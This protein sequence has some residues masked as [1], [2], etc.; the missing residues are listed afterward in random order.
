MGKRRGHGEGS[1]HLRSDGRWSAVANIGWVGGKRKRKYLY[2]QTRKQVADALKE[3][4]A[5]QTLGMNI[6][7]ARQTVSAF[8]KNWLEQTVKRNNRPRTY[9]KYESDFRHHIE[10]T[11]GKY[12]LAKLTPDHIQDL[13]NDLDDAGL[14][15]RTIRNVRAVI[16][17]ALNKAMKRRHIMINV[18]TLVDV[19]GEIVFKATYLNEEQAVQLL[20]AVK[21]HRF[22]VLYRIALELGLRKGEILGLR[23]E[24]VDFDNAV[25][26]ITGTL[27]R[28]NG[29][30]ERSPTKTEASVRTIALAENL[31]K[32]LKRHKE[33]QDEMRAACGERWVD[34]GLVF[35]TGI[36]TG[37]ETTTLSLHFKS[38][39]AEAKLP[40]ST[41][42][43]D[44]RHSCATL[45]VKRNVHPRVIMAIL[46][47]TQISTTM[48]TYA[49]VLKEVQRDAINV[50]D[51]LL[52]TEEA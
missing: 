24:D 29:R 1:I 5:N 28:Q 8:I 30:L 9:V 32:A 46:G 17:A 18:A 35:T 34:T 41:R 22:E 39:L 19:P 3:L 40:T 31:L 15:Y 38:L 10:P 21:G 25:I 42:F 45:M 4:H 13:L 11:I 20:K 12:Q 36:G 6:A 51:S 16:R 7:P 47:H 50:M 43:H 48:N 33:R 2:G 26:Q 23:W 14:S 49:H 52:G 44:L 27:Q 37:I